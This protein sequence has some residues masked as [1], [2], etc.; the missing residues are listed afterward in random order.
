MQMY[1]FSKR[2]SRPI[3]AISLASGWTYYLVA[4]EEQLTGGEIGTDGV[5]IDW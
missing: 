4:S 3:S 5:R 2:A 1:G